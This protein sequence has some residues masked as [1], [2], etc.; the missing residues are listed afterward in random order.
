M[1]DFAAAVRLYEDLK[2][3]RGQLDSEATDLASNLSAAKAQN[4]ALTGVGHEKSQDTND[5]YEVQ[6]NLACEYIALGN[7]SEAET[8]LQKAESNLFCGLAK[9]RTM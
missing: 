9:Y 7:L 3:G 5:S 8:A 4:A 6:F 2:K 1:E